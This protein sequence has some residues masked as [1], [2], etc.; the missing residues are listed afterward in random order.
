MKKRKKIIRNRNHI[1]IQTKGEGF[2]FIDT[3]S[4]LNDF[5]FESGRASRN[6]ERE[7]ERYQLFY[8]LCANSTAVQYRK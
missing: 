1:V 8:Y 4:L 3:E 2:N 5:D 6:G 7:G